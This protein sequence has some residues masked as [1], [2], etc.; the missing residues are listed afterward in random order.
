MPTELGRAVMRPIP[1][2]GTVTF[3]IG[4]VTGSGAGGMR[5]VRWRFVP[6]CALIGAA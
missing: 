5:Q 3:T 2:A 1:N 6:A 4:P